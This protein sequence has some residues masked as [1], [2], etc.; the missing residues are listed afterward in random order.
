MFGSTLADDTESVQVVVW[1]VGIAT[2][3]LA[4]VAANQTLVGSLGTPR[5]I[6]VVPFLATVILGVV[7]R[8]IL[9]VTIDVDRSIQ[10]RRRV[11]LWFIEANY[12]TQDLSNEDIMA[13]LTAVAVPGRVIAMCPTLTIQKPSM[14][15]TSCERKA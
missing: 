4:L 6:V 12:A 14:S 3:F 2:G 7:H 5:G 8:L 10:M 13:T 11:Q 9:Q 1:L 15:T